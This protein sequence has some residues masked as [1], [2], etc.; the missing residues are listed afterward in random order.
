[1]AKVRSPRN[2]KAEIERLRARLGEAEETLAAIRKGAVDAISVEGPEGSQVFTLRSA[3]HPYRTL[4]ESIS[5]GVA[6]MNADG[7]VLFCNDRLS[8]ILGRPAEKLMGTALVNLVA[9]E[10]RE[11]FRQL[12]ACSLKG[13]ARE[14]MRFRHKGGKCMPVLASLREIPGESG[15][16]HG[17][18]LVATDLNEIRQAEEALWES[19]S[20]LA[21]LFQSAMDAILTV[22]GG[23]RILLFNAA[24]EKMFGCTAAEAAGQ[25]IT[26]FIPAQFPA[27]HDAPPS[28]AS[29]GSFTARVMGNKSLLGVRTDGSEFQVEASLSAVGNGHKKFFTVI[30]RDV[31]E[32]L[33]AA[34]IRDRMA[35]IVDSSDDAIISK[36][37]NGTITDWNHGAEKIF[38]YS[39]SEMVGESITRLF[40]RARVA[41]EHDILGRIAR[42]MTVEHYETARVRKDGRAI[43]VS[44]TISPIKDGSGRIV[45]ASK[46]ARDISE[47][48]R[49]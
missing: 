14:E 40:P 39:A 2:E 10:D 28:E 38:G 34:E 5:E 12:L 6:S 35:A 29:S 9:E 3:E 33:R 22:D 24:A 16:A 26:R 15:A 41:E 11:R 45:G 1:M 25:P 17:I 48:K 21:S 27:D 7:I 20:R 31:T 32:R 18:C 30:L 23:E 47:R 37:L 49:R 44:V 13:E 4:A 43:D 36:D 42:A 8:Q 19:E 46:I